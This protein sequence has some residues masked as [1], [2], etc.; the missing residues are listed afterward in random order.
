[1]YFELNRHVGRDF[2]VFKKQVVLALIDF[3]IVLKVHS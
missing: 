1:M 2:L 3:E